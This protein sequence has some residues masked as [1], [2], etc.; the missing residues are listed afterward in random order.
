MR[1]NGITY[2]QV[3]EIGF[4]DVDIKPLVEKCERDQMGLAVFEPLAEVAIRFNLSTREIATL[5]S[6]DNPRYEWEVEREGHFYTIEIG[7]AHV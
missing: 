3:R 6:F 2:E 4:T 5:R 7:R 1:L